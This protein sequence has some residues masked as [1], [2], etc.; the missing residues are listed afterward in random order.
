MSAETNSQTVTMEG[1]FRVMIHLV[2]NKAYSIHF[3]QSLQIGIRDKLKMID[4]MGIFHFKA[5][6][7]L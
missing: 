4:E 1:P 2:G 3:L 5:S 7:N 6:K